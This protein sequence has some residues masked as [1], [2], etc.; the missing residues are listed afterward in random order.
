LQLDANDLGF[1]G[2]FLSGVI[3]YN[4]T[5]WNAGFGPN[6]LIVLGGSIGY[7]QKSIKATMGSYYYRYQYDYYVDVREVADVR[8]YFGE[9]R[10]DPFRWLSGRLSY[11]FEQFDR[12]IHTVTVSVV[13][14]F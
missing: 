10:Y 6:S 5:F 9:L 7:E 12:N 4:Y 3:E 13:E 1:M 14:R 8:S 11:R 2:F